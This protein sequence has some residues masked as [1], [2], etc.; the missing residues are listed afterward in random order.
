M[1]GTLV[2]GS[3]V[4]LMSR[5]CSLFTAFK[6]PHSTQASLD[7]VYRRL[8][9]ATLPLSTPVGV[10]CLLILSPLPK[11]KAVFGPSVSPSFVAGPLVSP[12]LSFTKLTPFSKIAT[13]NDDA[14][15][16]TRKGK[17]GGGTSGVTVVPMGRGE[18]DRLST[19]QSGNLF[20][21]S[22][23][24]SLPFWEVTVI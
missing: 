20:S 16:V 18:S 1:T 2:A 9:L 14:L 5:K 10:L 13:V 17:P 12:S 21:K 4:T 19:T 23:Q 15:V 8:V 24:T 3:G 7:F 6:S 11:A 22:H